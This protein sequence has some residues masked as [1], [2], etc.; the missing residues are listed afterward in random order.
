MSRDAGVPVAVAVP[1]SVR[2]AASKGLVLRRQYGRGGTSVGLHTANNQH[3]PP[4]NGYIAWLLWG[5]DA[6]RQWSEAYTEGL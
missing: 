3:D 6:G 5:G 2:A 1:K 4:S